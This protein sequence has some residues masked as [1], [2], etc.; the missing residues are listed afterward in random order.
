MYLDPDL[1]SLPS[2]SS[3]QTSTHA[4][5]QL[6]LIDG[7]YLIFRYPFLANDNMIGVDMTT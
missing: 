3:A 7:L 2:L 5:I 6:Q 4:L 1:Q